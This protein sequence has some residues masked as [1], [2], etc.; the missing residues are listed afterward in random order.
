M[1]HSNRILQQHLQICNEKSFWFDR[2]KDSL[3]TVALGSS[4]GYYGFN[5]QIVLNSFN[6]CSPSQDLKYAF[7]LYEKS[8]RECSKIEN[9]VLFYS[10]F[11]PGSEVEKS[12]SERFVAVAINDRFN[13]GVD[14]HDN[15][16]LYLNECAKKFVFD[17]SIEALQKFGY[18][19]NVIE[20]IPDAYGAVNRAND[21]IRFNIKSD[22]IGYLYQILGLAY[23]KKQKVFIVLPPYRS[24]YKECIEKAGGDRYSGLNIVIEKI[25][26]YFTPI[27]L[28]FYCNENFID[29]DFIDFDHLNP[30]GN[31]PNKLT[32]LI[33]H[34]MKLFGANF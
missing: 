8:I 2:A 13:L 7:L 33:V 6:L 31:G 26:T 20:S 19:P 16:L 15:S 1:N 27:V 12:P 29:S 18:P 30:S 5:S 9:L 17:K 4:H 11:S 25:C 34:N 23:H 21:H 3:K 22:S 10:I 32:E 24:D 14:Y 28:D